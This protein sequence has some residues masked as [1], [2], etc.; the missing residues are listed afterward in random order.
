MAA[1][2]AIF[3]R[4]RFT[5]VSFLIRP[6]SL[7]QSELQAREEDAADLCASCIGQKSL[8]TNRAFFTPSA[9][10]YD[11]AAKICPMVATASP[12]GGGEQVI[13]EKK[14]FQLPNLPTTYKLFQSGQLMTVFVIIPERHGKCNLSTRAEYCNT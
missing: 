7:V 10:N 9:E 3:P 12:A 14:P 8:V 4:V 5:A 1:R 6:E 11:S 13:G 2:R